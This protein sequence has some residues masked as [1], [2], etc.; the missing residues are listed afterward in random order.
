MRRD[1]AEQH[2]ILDIATNSCYVVYKID[3]PKQLKGN[4]FLGHHILLAYLAQLQS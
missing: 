3:K 4:I 1:L 2:H